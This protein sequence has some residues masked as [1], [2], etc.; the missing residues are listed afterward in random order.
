VIWRAI[1]T[2]N[3]AI[4]ENYGRAM[5]VTFA[6]H[7]PDAVQLTV[8]TEKFDAGQNGSVRFVDLDQAAPWLAEFKDRYRHPMY[9]GG[10]SRRD[11]RHDAV[12]FAHKVAAIGA[13]AED[14]SRETDCLIW[15]DADIVTHAPVTLDWLASL[16]PEPA[17]V[18]WLDRQRTYPECGFV[19]FRLPEARPVIGAI[20]EAYRTG[21]IFKLAEWHDSFVIQHYVL[22]SGVAVHSLSGPEG[23]KHTG[24]PWISSPLA[25][26][27][28]HLK[29]ETRKAHGRSLP[30][31]LMAARVPRPEPYWC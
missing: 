20:V 9:N 7:W 24:H 17:V 25:A 19:M 27:C 10:P 12:R 29:G 23:R 1:T 4:W 26:C 2:A 30:Q 6:R 14:V 31:D 18:A 22:K 15:L 28:D 21:A 3:A 16:F 11:Y 8:Y 13:A 5:A